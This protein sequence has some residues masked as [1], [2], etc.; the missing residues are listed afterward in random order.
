MFAVARH[1]DVAVPGVITDEAYPLHRAG[2]WYR[3]SDWAASPD[4]HLPD[5]ANGVDL[6]P[7]P[8]PPAPETDTEE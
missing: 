3:V 5:Y 1:P 6:D 7:K 4:F 8:A 2:G